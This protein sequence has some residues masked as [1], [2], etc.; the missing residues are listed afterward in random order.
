MLCR[1]SPAPAPHHCAPQG[2]PRLFDQKTSG[3]PLQATAHPPPAMDPFEGRIRFSGLL[4]RLNA[5]HTSHTKA[6][7]FALKNR[8]M[9]EDLHSCILEQLERNNTNTMNNRAN[10]MYFIDTLCEMAQKE[11]VL[12][13][14]RMMQRDILRVVEAVCPADGSGAANVRVVRDVSSAPR[15]SKRGPTAL[16]LRVG[17]PQTAA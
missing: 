7:V 3:L 10:I 5:S 4:E 1:T 9:D 14:V 8:N 6:A 16:T 12:E 17:A 15:A 13:F 2:A 11:G